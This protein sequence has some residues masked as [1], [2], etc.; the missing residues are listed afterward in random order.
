MISF[1]PTTC[2]G[3]VDMMSETML[4]VEYMRMK[5]L[6]ASTAVPT[7]RNGTLSGTKTR[8]KASL[9]SKRE[10]IKSVL[11]NRSSTKYKGWILLRKN[12]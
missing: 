6:T 1:L 8:S 3:L 12:F 4:N 11:I 10:L 9:A 7:P 2:L 5:E